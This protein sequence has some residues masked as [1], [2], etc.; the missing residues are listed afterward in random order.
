MFSKLHKMQLLSVTVMLTVAL[1]CRAA[2]IGT[3]KRF[4]FTSDIFHYDIVTF[5]VDGGSTST[6][7]GV[8]AQQAGGSEITTVKSD[9]TTAMKSSATAKEQS[10]L[11]E[12][13]N[14][15]FSASDDSSSQKPKVV[16]VGNTA[17]DVTTA[18][19]DTAAISR[20]GGGTSPKVQDNG[21]GSTPP[22]AAVNVIGTFHDEMNCSVYFNGDINIAM[23]LLVQT[24]AISRFY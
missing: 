6:K 3:G 5:T 9:G 4:G 17:A 7:Y 2:S 21:G 11:E 22:K 1:L 20:D 14:H 23:Q 16:T 8:T 18:H 13:V 15:A 24:P 12:L 10:T 19:T